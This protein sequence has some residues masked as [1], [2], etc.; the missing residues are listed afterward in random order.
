MHTRAI[1]DACGMQRCRL[2]DKWGRQSS[3]QRAAICES[4]ALFPPALQGLNERRQPGI[5]LVGVQRAMIDRQRDISHRPDLDRVDAV[6]LSYDDALLHFSDAKNCRLRLID[7]DGR[8]DQR[9][10]H[11]MV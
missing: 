8:S 6:D 5:C 1:V 10:R 4:P 9:A 3:S 2:G 11:A 7:D